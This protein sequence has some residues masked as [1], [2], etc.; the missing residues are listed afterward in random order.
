MKEK[1]FVF[2]KRKG[3]LDEM[4]YLKSDNIIFNLYKTKL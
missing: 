2:E 3:L 4:I 1:L